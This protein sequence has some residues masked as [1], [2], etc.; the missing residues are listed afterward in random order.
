MILVKFWWIISSA[1]N[2]F[3]GVVSGWLGDVTLVSGLAVYLYHKN[4]HV[5]G[6]PRLGKHS[7]AGG[8]IVTCR[9]HHPDMGPDHVITPEVVAKA[10][11]QYHTQNIK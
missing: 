8:K 7:V 1:T 6:C 5:K 9:R 2:A 4:C 11:E 3:Y 10:H